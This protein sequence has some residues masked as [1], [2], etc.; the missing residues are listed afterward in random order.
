MLWWC[1][2]MK[3]SLHQEIKCRRI[4]HFISCSLHMFIAN[5][6]IQL[7]NKWYIWYILCHYYWHIV[8]AL[9]YN[10]N[11]KTQKYVLN[12]WFFKFQYYGS[13]NLK[14]F[15]LHTC[16]GVEVRYES[17]ARKGTEARRASWC[18][19]L[20]KNLWKSSFG[21][22]ETKNRLHLMRLMRWLQPLT[23]TVTEGSATVSS[24]Q[25]I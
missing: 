24:G 25:K 22:K 3:Q 15:R 18:W 9:Y 17:P 5:G 6:W 23:A 7:L 8:M 13:F 20:T 19:I 16:W 12:W 1:G 21:L 2:N 14:H 10:S 11:N 4:L